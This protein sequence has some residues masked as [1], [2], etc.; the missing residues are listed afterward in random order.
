MLESP[1]HMLYGLTIIRAPQRIVV[2]YIRGNIFDLKYVDNVN[3]RSKRSDTLGTTVVAPLPPEGY[4]ES[5][6]V[7]YGSHWPHVLLNP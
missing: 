2:G 6:A 3:F 5:Y 1:S 7:C 4:P